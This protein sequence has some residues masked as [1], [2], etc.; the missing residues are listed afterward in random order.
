MTRPRQFDKAV[1]LGIAVRCFWYRGYE[2][3]SIRDLIAATGV[4][5]A[6]LYGAFGDKRALYCQVLEHYSETVILDR[7]RRC[8]RHSSTNGGITA[9]FD[10]VI[11]VSLSDPMCKGCLIVNSAI[12]AA[13]HDTE[14]QRIVM[15]VTMEIEAFFR[16]CVRSG[17]LAGTIDANQPP[18][19][20]ARLLLAVF[21]GLCALVRVRPD[22][23]LVSGMLLPM[24]ALLER[25]DVS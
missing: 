17:Q 1:V 16:R 21:A 22:R 23:S 25:S 11:A 3:T 20:L 13:H 4:S 19:D 14:F 6:S 2:A 18:D 9:Y 24:F 8:E 5:G 12:E 10:E 15:R 7:I